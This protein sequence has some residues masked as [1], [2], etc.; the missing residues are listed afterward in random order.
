MGEKYLGV[1]KNSGTCGTPKSS[2]FFGGFPLFSPSKNRNTPIFWKPQRRWFFP[3]LVAGIRM[4]MVLELW[5]CRSWYKAFYNRVSCTWRW[6]VS[7][8]MDGE[9]EGVK[10]LNSTFTTNFAVVEFLPLDQILHF[11]GYMKRFKAD[12]WFFTSDSPYTFQC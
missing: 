12:L 2:M 4:Q 8:R 3:E 7:L 9:L 6:W 5:V 11:L 1:S 10:P